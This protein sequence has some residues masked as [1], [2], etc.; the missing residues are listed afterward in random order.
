MESVEEIRQVL[1]AR[2]PLT[3]KEDTSAATVPFRPVRRPPVA[4]VCI[5]DDGRDD[6]EW[7]RIRASRAVIGR[8]EGAIVIPHDDQMSGRHAE[9]VRQ[10][11]GN[12]YRWYLADL[13]STNGTFVRVGK[14]L[15]RHGQE[16][17]IGS[18][19]LRF[20]G[21]PQVAAGA[22]SADQ[23]RATRGWKSVAPTDL[24]PSLV[25]LAEQ[26]EGQRW[27]LTKSDTW[28]GRDSTQCPVALADDP[29]VNPRHARLLRDA[30]GRWHLEN[31][32]TVNGTWIR[33]TKIPLEGAGQFQLGEQRFLVRV[34]G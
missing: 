7:L 13:Q 20:E 25:E 32:A 9:L 23:S 30:K 6:G 21:A 17:L 16:I 8:S 11:E 18:R 31:G 10:L 5:L 26:G 4:L 24:L 12:R 19:R 27:L 29:L 15:L 34:P 1:Q 3:T 14:V 33:I 28:I 22:E 2:R